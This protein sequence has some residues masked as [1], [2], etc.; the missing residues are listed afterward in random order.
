MDFV[1]VLE[2][3]I[4]EKV[5]IGWIGK[6]SF[7]F[8][9]EVGLWFFLGE[10]FINV[11]FF[12]DLLIEEGCGSCIVC[13]IICFINVIVEFYKVDGCKC[14]LYF[15]IEFDK[16]ILEEFRFLMGNCIYGCDDC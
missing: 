10:F 7:M 1:F 13:L 8:N 5:G 2:Y 6:Y 16:D 15:I 12:V 11:L 9:K 3:V 14:I 4:V